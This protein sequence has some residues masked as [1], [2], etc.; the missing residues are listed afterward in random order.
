MGR[1]LDDDRYLSE[2]WKSFSTIDA[3]GE[4][5]VI[6]FDLITEGMTVR[7][8]PE[9]ALTFTF[10]LPLPDN[11]EVHI[12][13]S[14]ATGATEIKNNLLLTINDPNFDSTWFSDAA[15]NGVTLTR[16]EAYPEGFVACQ[17]RRMQ[18]SSDLLTP[19]T[20]T[21]SVN[22]TTTGVVSAVG[23][24]TATVNAIVA[25]VNA[26]SGT[27][28]VTAVRVSAV[29]DYVIFNGDV[30]GN[31]F[32]VTAIVIAGSLTTATVTTPPDAFTFI[33]PTG[34]A[35]DTSHLPNRYL[36]AATKWKY[37]S[38]A[39]PWVGV[40]LQAQ[41]AFTGDVTTFVTNLDQIEIVPGKILVAKKNATAN[42]ASGEFLVTAVLI[43]SLQNMVD[44]INDPVYNSG[45]KASLNSTNDAVLL[46]IGGYALADIT[47]LVESVNG[48]WLVTDYEP[49]G[50]GDNA[51]TGFMKSIQ[52][53][54]VAEWR[55]QTVDDVGTW[56]TWNA[57]Q[58]L[59]CLLY[60]SP[61][62]R[63]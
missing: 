51:S 41:I 31:S 37:L 8:S 1:E 32:T 44:T 63:D 20:I 40:Y 35:L 2:T 5:D 43:D 25:A 4:I 38:V 7:L 18:F 48:T 36:D 10:S 53:L 27:T 62:P 57:I 60:T 22:G 49:S 15:T 46:K 12:P 6:S 9:K 28:G 14:P 34:G 19:A 29:R 13:T 61:S 30:D 23:T 42:P 39:V 52:P 47:L 56:S 3:S 58:V 54:E 24:H 55:Y 21:F 59:S 11:G 17:R 16:S 50:V 45:V 26:I 33:Q